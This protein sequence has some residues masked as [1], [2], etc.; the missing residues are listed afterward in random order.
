MNLT[1]LEA[2]N[3]CLERIQDLTESILIEKG[4]I[5]IP[6]DIIK[7]VTLDGFSVFSMPLQKIEGEDK[8]T[9]ILMVNDN[10][11]IL[12][13]D[14]NK[15]IILEE[16]LELKR[17]RFVTAHEY[18]HF[19]LHKKIETS[20]FITKNTPRR[21]ANTL[22]ED[23]SEIEADTFARCILMPKI[24]VKNTIDPLYDSDKNKD[25]MIK[26]ISEKFN[27]SLNKAEIRLQELNYI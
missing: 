22:T 12:K 11:N 10:D 5:T 16:S 18:G 25:T 9:G 4:D 6:I 26:I 8:T 3:M 1:I 15:V 13:L 21:N 2:G 19:K 27:V 24:F 20:E 7:L 23:K 14:T 17:R